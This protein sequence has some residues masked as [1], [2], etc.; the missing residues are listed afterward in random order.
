M[1]FDVGCIDLERVRIGLAAVV[2]AALQREE[3]RAVR[4]RIVPLA[5]RILG[6]ISA[7]PRRDGSAVCS[8]VTTGSQ[9][10]RLHA[11][12]RCAANAGRSAHQQRACDGYGSAPVRLWQPVELQEVVLNW[13]RHHD[14]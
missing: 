11:S 10:G 3:P 12:L 6:G 13:R 4:V 1:R 14:A 9:A 8:V 2:G 5:Q 7:P